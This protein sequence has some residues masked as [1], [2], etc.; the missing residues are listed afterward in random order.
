MGGL[1]EYGTG[2]IT[3]TAPYQQIEVNIQVDQ[4]LQISVDSGS[5]AL[6][7]DPDV[8]LGQNWAGTGGVVTEKSAVE[9][10]TNAN[11]GY[12]LLI[13]LAGNTA[14]GSAVLD[15][16]GTSAN[17]ITSSTGNRVT[18]ENNFAFKLTN[19][20]A[21]TVD[22][23]TNASTAISGAGLS[24]PTNTNIDN[25]YYYLNVDYT[26]PSDDYKGTV[27]YTAVGSF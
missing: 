11:N 21:T 6:Q 10:K 4:S 14:T 25:I 13:K 1:I 18:T 16:S 20:G 12:S 27:T 2:S 15:G 26:T 8:Q 3:I 7:V 24:S 17:Q 5:V 23:F 9:V 19:S 22:D